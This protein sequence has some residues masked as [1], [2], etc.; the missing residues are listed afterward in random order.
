MKHS[1]TIGL[2]VVL[3]IL[4][5]AAV[6]DTFRWIPGDTKEFCVVRATWIARATGSVDV[7]TTKPI[8]GAVVRVVTNPGTPAP[9]DNYDIVLEDV[10]GADIM[11][12]TL[13]DRDVSNS[14][15][16]VALIY[17]DGSDRVYGNPV[18]D[19]PLIMRVDNNSTG[20]AQGQVAIYIKRK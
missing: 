12:G 18:V 1:Q 2:I 17:D 3:G 6:S 9:S 14:E 10:D 15:Q 11:G 19:G 4:L 16:A 5:V 13:S 7:F 20:L 8:N